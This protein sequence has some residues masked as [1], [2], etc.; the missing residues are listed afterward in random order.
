MAIYLEVLGEGLNSIFISFPGVFFQGG[1]GL[2]RLV[3]TWGVD[4]TGPDASHGLHPLS[5]FAAFLFLGL[6]L[7]HA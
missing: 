5:G 6:Q 7:K 1:P 2:Y 4:V 3:S